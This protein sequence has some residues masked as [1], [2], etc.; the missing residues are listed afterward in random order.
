MF[1]FVSTVFS[2]FSGLKFPSFANVVSVDQDA[3]TGKSIC[4]VGHA[5]TRMIR[6]YSVTVALIHAA[7]TTF[8]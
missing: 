7:I 1:V 3:L 6:H 4:S 5:I 2:V 8:R